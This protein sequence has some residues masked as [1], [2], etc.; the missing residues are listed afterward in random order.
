MR[1]T[2]AKKIYLGDE[3]VIL[4]F[5][6]YAILM[7]Y[8]LMLNSTKGKKL[9]DATMSEWAYK[10]NYE[11]DLNEITDSDINAHFVIS[12]IQEAIT[13]IEEELI[14]ALRSETQNLLIKY[15]GRSNFQKIVNSNDGIIGFLGLDNEE[16][17]IDKPT[18]LIE[19]AHKLKDFLHMAV[20]LNMPYE[21]IP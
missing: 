20:T 21:V 9:F 11:L 4:D 1:R 6:T 18:Y 10:V 12:E 17:Y 15:G 3:E 2:R 14:N 5:G 19:I 7:Y 8:A 16:F 13:F